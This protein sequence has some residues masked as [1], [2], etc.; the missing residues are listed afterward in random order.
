MNAIDALIF[1]MDGV[2][3]DSEP[4]QLRATQAAMGERGATY[5]ERDNQAFFGTTDAEHLRV[6]R[7]LFNLGPTTAE[8]VEAKRRHLVTLIRSE[9]RPLPGVPTVP[10]RLRGSGLRLGLVS[11]SARSVIKTVLDTVGLDQAFEIVV[12]GDEVARG[13]PAPDGFLMAAR[14]LGIAPD[15]CLVIED[16]RNGVLAAKAAGMSAAAVPCQA[17]SHEDFSPADLVLPSLEALPKAL[18]RNGQETT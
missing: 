3:I 7:I 1:D 11:A 16:S 17:T 5:T 12:S 6:L 9:G 18:G 4:F 8:L 13:K 2:L 10:L 14:R 15:R